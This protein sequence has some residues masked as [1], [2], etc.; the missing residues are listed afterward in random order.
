M[1]LKEKE[2]V[3]LF[4]TPTKIVDNKIS[5]QLEK[6]QYMLGAVCGINPGENGISAEK[7]LSMK[8]RDLSYLYGKEEHNHGY[9]NDVL[10]KVSALLEYFELYRL[11]QSPEIYNRRKR[12][13]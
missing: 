2:V 9:I 3:E 4:F 10:P 6:Y 11:K 7:A 12:V 8:L 5:V 1:E 13:E